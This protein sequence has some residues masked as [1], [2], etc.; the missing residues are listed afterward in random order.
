MA[1]STLSSVQVDGT[2]Y[3][4]SEFVTVGVGSVVGSAMVGKFGKLLNLVPI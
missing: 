2:H 4:L 1:V 3:V